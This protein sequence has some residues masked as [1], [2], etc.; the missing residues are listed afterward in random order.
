VDLRQPRPHRGIFEMSRNCLE[1]VRTKLIPT[2][3][4]GEDGVPQGAC[5]QAAF[6]GARVTGRGLS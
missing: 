1:Q 2:L 3:G 6:M 5:E 4:F